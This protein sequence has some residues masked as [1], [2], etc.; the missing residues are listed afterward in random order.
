VYILITLI[1]S[2]Q[3]CE[4][5]ENYS[6]LKNVEIPDTSSLK[7][8]R[9]LKQTNTDLV[10]EIASCNRVDS[11]F[12]GY[13]GTT[14]EQYLRFE[15]L[16]KYA[17]TDELTK[18]LNNKSAVVRVYAFWALQD[19]KNINLKRIILEHIQDTLSF[20]SLQGCMGSHSYVNLHFLAYGKYCCLSEKEFKYYMQVVSKCYPKKEWEFIS[21]FY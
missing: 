16:S 15:R 9:S 10:D 8:S 12:T 21:K 19:R 13:S 4:Q 20:A 18:L 3:S 2:L 5:R 7:V 14:S 17:T 1:Q 6:L 11:K